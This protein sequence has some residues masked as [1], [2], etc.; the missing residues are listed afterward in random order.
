MP[1]RDPLLS[2]P[3]EMDCAEAFLDLLQTLEAAALQPGDP[4]KASQL[5]Y[6]LVIAEA[7]SPWRLRCTECLCLMSADW[8]W[9]SLICGRCDSR[10]TARDELLAK[11]V[12]ET[13]QR[14]FSTRDDA[15]QIE[16]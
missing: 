2:P 3:G 4:P 6:A 16:L 9:R 14:L 7:A 13:R 5:D 12:A 10:P 11:R 8:S 1:E 15:E